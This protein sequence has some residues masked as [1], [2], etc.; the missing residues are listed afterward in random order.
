VDYYEEF[1]K[2]K[3]MLP[4]ISL[5]CQGILDDSNYY[6]VNTAYIISGL[7]YSDLGILNSKMIL[8]YYSSLTQTIRGGYLRFIRQYLE[9]IPIIQTIVLE[10]KVKEI[11]SQ[12]S[13]N[14]FVD[15]ASL[16]A[17]IDQLV[18][19]LYGLTDEEIEIIENAVK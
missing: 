19:Q 2:P 7:N 8:F 14:P 11:I 9:Q 4:D 18:Y 15:T 1:E 17:E 3:I 16:E 5:S 10:E 13:L 12:K 6:C